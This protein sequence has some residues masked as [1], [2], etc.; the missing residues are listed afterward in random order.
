M[1]ARKN[2]GN[3]WEE[4]STWEQ[5]EPEQ[6]RNWEKSTSQVLSAGTE[7][8][9]ERNGERGRRDEN[10]GRRE[11][12]PRR[13]EEDRGRSEEDLRRDEERGRRDE[14]EGK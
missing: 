13:R 9:R 8:E 5:V 3:S 2:E 7:E 4:S 14:G 11:E 1:E 10:Q 12:D 6:R